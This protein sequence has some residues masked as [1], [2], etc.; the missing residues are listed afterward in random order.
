MLFTKYRGSTDE[1]D[2]K[3]V[4]KLYGDYPLWTRDCAI[5]LNSQISVEI[6][7]SQS[8]R[9]QVVITAFGDN[10]SAIITS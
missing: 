6:M 5:E 2:T 10:M 4:T 9:D 3:I 7:K 8:Y 1:L